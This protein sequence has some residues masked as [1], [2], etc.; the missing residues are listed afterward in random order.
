MCSCNRSIFLEVGIAHILDH[1]DLEDIGIVELF[2][3]KLSLV[4]GKDID[5]MNLPIFLGKGSLHIEVQIILV[6]NHKF[7]WLDSRRFLELGKHKHF[8]WYPRILG[9]GILSS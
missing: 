8:V 7:Y 6:G 4:L 3:S 5:S 1:K 2:H 9:L